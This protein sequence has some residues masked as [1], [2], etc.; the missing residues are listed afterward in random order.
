MSQLSAR[1]RIILSIDTS[2]RQDAERLAAVA[3]AAGARFVKMGL[4]LSSAESWLYCSRL[5]HRHRLDWVADAKLDDISHTVAGKG[6]KDNGGTVRNIAGLA[7]PPFGITIHTSVGLEA[8]RKAQQVA[9]DIK[10]LG[11]TVLTSISDE[12]C[13][14]MY[15]PEFDPAQPPSA[16]VMAAF[17]RATVMRRARSAAKAGLAGFVSSPLE[18]GMIKSDSETQELFAMI[19]GTRSAG[20]D[21]GDQNRVATPGEAIQDGADLLVVGRQITQAEDPAAAYQALVTE[22]E[23][24]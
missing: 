15:G 12:E 17:R 4:E 7:Y 11:V 8:M 1:E 10:M 2:R 22:I 16:E 14:A 13:H 21:R 20:V 9:G 18:V 3:Q 23:A 24:V 5:A 6:T 19:P